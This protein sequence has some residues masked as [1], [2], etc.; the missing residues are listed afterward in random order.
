MEWL[1]LAGAIYVIGAVVVSWQFEKWL[2]EDYPNRGWT[3]TYTAIL[4]PIG[5]TLYYLSPR[6]QK[7]RQELNEKLENEKRVSAELKQQAMEAEESYQ[8]TKKFMLLWLE[9]QRDQLQ[10]NLE[11]TEEDDPGR[12]ILEESISKTDEM[13][14]RH[15]DPQL[16]EK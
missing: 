5:L 11:E 1:L 14:S 16:Q 10:R 9:K 7:E 13:L 12:A 15:K 2:P 3:I 8:N 6:M 4:W